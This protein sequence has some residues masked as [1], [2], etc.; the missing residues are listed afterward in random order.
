MKI[1]NTTA[2]GLTLA[3]SC[4]SNV[5]N[6][7]LIDL[8][9]SGSN[10]QGS[11]YL[12]SGGETSFSNAS[13]ELIYHIDDTA[14]L[15]YSSATH[16]QYENAILGTTLKLNGEQF[17]LTGDSAIGM[18]YLDQNNQYD[19]IGT[20]PLGGGY[21]SQLTAPGDLFPALISNIF[22]LSTLNI[23]EALYNTT[24]DSF[25]NS[26]WINFQGSNPITNPCNDP[27]F[28]F[29][30][31]LATSGGDYIS[32][33]ANG[34]SGT[35]EMLVTVSYTNS[36]PANNIPEPSTLAIFALAIFGL[37]ARRFKK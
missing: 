2:F 36:V 6:A 28:C 10:A 11:I 27:F 23:G 29:N 14:A 9:F 5:V 33:F 12:G 7:S 24:T 31:S 19:S 1:L 16:A 34:G 30:S 17:E 18:L 4:M 37:A 21:A 22:D 20:N 3:I 13:Y 26:S 8:T 35:S 32:M 25:N 15:T